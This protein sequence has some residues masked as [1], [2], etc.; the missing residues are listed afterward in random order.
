[1]P[2]SRWKTRS[3]FFD[4]YVHSQL[5]QTDTSLMLNHEYIFFVLGDHDYISQ[6][7]MVCLA[8]DF[9]MADCFMLFILL[10]SSCLIC[11]VGFHKL[12]T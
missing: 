10:L 11:S 5:P 4:H 1:M 6:L 8:I 12:R 2:T 9:T 7:G 3:V